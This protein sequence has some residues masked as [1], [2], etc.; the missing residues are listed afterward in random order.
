M[1]KGFL[2]V[3]AILLPALLIFQFGIQA[4]ALRGQVVAAGLAAA[5][6]YLG[7]F[8]LVGVARYRALRYRL[9]RTYWHGIRGGGEPGGWAYG[10][11]YVWKTVAGALVLGLLVPWSM[12]QL[13]NERWSRMS[14]GQHQFRSFADVEGL[15]RRWVLLLLSPFV[16]MLVI[17]PFFVL[18]DLTS[19]I[20]GGSVDAS[21]G[22]NDVGIILVAIGFVVIFYGTIAMLGVGYFAAYAR[23]AV[24]SLDLGQLTFQ[25]NAKSK[26]WLMLFLGHVGLVIVTLGVGLIFL[27]Y[28]NWSFF[29]RHLE[30]HGEV[31]LATLTQSE[32]TTATDGEG[33]ASAFDIGAI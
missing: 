22:Q 28:R 26:D 30:A 19:S 14:F 33:L 13:W 23:K 24:G 2:I 6:L 18:G 17:A 9:S 25:F 10:W 20:A 7:L 21:S 5:S 4:L 16:A 27:S 1:F 15:M 32:S 31:D 3:M 12:T 11:S 29:I 8:F